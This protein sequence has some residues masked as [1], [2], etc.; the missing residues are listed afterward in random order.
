MI[1]PSAKMWFLGWRRSGGCPS[2]LHVGSSI[3]PCV[4]HCSTR[5]MLA[6]GHKFQLRCFS[7]SSYL[8]FFS[9]EALT[10]SKTPSNPNHLVWPYWSS[11]ITFLSQHTSRDVLLPVSGRITCHR[12]LPSATAEKWLWISSFRLRFF[13]VFLSSSSIWI[14]PTTVDWNPPSRRSAPSIV[15]L[16]LVPSL[17]LS[18]VNWQPT[19]RT[20]ILMGVSVSQF[21]S[22]MYLPTHD[23]TYQIPSIYLEPSPVLL[24]PLCSLSALTHPN[25][26]GL[27]R[28]Y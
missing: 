17:A 5:K 16:S 12:T 26:V 6:E 13:L 2:L 10:A 8:S 11:W 9:S 28:C 14:F 18:T 15:L 27:S 4:V 19:L 21:V 1:A 24:L 23:S 7:S 3:P 22:L 20:N 25:L